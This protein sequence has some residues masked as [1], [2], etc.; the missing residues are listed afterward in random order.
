METEKPH[1]LSSVTWRHRTAGGAAQSWCEGPRPR[2]TDVR[3]RE[4][5]DPP[6]Q[7]KNTPAFWLFGPIQPLRGWMM[8]AHSGEG[9]PDHSVLTQMLISLGDTL[10]HSEIMLYQLSGDP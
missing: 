2:G 4:G 1:D 3:G 6:V 10:T 5:M 9:H 8:S 7:A